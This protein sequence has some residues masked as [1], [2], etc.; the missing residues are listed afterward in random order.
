MTK[1]H[2]TA[3]PRPA[4]VSAGLPRADQTTRI[5]VGFGRALRGAGVTVPVGSVVAYSEAL[6]AV[7]VERR[8]PVYWAGRAALIRRPEDIEVYDRTFAAYWQARP[9]T[10]IALAA[11]PDEVTVAFD[12][13]DEPDEAGDDGDE[14]REEGEILSVR[15]SRTELLRQQD[16][17]T[18]SADEHDEA[19]RII[20][21]MRLSTVTR[22]S[23]RL[24]PAVRGGG[25]ARRPDLRRTVRLALAHEG[26]PIRR[27]YREPDDKP[28][29]IV[30]IVDVSG[31]MESYARQLVRFAQA[32]VVGRGR[33]EVF[34]L[35][36]RLTRITRELGSRDPDRALARAATRVVD[37]SG[38]TRLGDGMRAFND[39]WGIR[40]MARGSVV[41]ILSDG[42]DRGDPEVLSAQME[43]LH[44]VTYRLV[45]VNPL[46]AGPGYAP[47]ARGM[48][49]ALPHLDHFVEGH[50]LASLE[51]LAELLTKP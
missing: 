29:R 37:W 6:A 19:R 17:A 42:W 20:A 44:R 51:S 35:G 5:A 43:R 47:L 34:A 9:A 30:L 3:P 50:S 2:P 14:D 27:R 4:L 21:R 25:S 16:F 8:A 24:R 32:A 38:G 41:V 10:G 12:D 13:G 45:W 31:S 22:P 49:A 7:G 28:R 26:E 33:V 1:A 15:F 40:G 18:Y 11:P 23:R 36:T 46:K 48:A 39:E